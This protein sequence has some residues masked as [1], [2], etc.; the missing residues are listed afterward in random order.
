[1]SAF[2]PNLLSAGCSIYAA[3]SALAVLGGVA[4][5]DLA[6]LVAHGQ[7]RLEDSLLQVVKVLAAAEDVLPTVLRQRARN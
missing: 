4:G 7:L 1:M 6:R 3:F 2:L 5:Q